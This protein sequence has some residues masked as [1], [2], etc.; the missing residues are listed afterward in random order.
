MLQEEVILRMGFDP[1]AV[2]AGLASTKSK[3]VEFAQSTAGQ[4][5]GAFGV[6]KILGGLQSVI[7]KFGDIKDQAENNNVSTDF[8]QGLGSVANVTNSSLESVQKGIVKLN[9]AIGQAKDGQ[10]TYVDDFAKLGITLDDLS[11]MNTEE[12]FYRIADGMKATDDIGTK[13][14]VT[15]DLLGRSGSDM[16]TLLSQGG[17]QIRQLID[18]AQKLSEGDIKVIAQAKDDLQSLHD[19]VDTWTGWALARTARLFRNIGAMTSGAFEGSI[20]GGQYLESLQAA[21]ASAQAQAQAEAQAV[22]D[23]QKQAKARR[24]ADDA[25]F[26]QNLKLKE[27][28]AQAGKDENLMMAALIMKREYLSDILKHDD[29]DQKKRFQVE[30]DHENT[31]TKI[32]QLQAQIA[33]N[34]AMSLGKWMDKA[35]SLANLLER[36]DTAMAD[37]TKFSLNE[38]A[39]RTITVSRSSRWGRRRTWQETLPENQAAAAAQDVLRLEQQA[40]DARLYG[41]FGLSD[42][43][44]QR[45]LSLRQRLSDY[46]TSNEANPFKGMSDDIKA[47]RKAL[48]KLGEAANGKGIAVRTPDE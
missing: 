5:A 41:N 46:I 33:S 20:A 25:S 32:K 12:V 17:D 42:Q 22:A 16:V 48:D 4:L 2:S 6:G 29:L 40:K 31:V 1:R 13:T 27:I 45:A 11:R 36:R 44:N 37:R 9:Q 24:E 43:L 23:A 35:A 30:L 34:A 38:L 14:K 8:L 28:R 15:M 7:E 39:A 21:A 10:K 19:T 47:Q 18:G 3:I 26:E